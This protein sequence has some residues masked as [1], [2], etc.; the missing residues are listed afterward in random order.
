VQSTTAE[1]EPESTLAARVS[2]SSSPIGGPPRSPWTIL[3]APVRETFVPGQ[4]AT[5]LL[6]ALREEQILR[7]KAGHGFAGFNAEELES[8]AEVVD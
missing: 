7:L 4:E 6:R 1:T 3:V 8:W 5:A 2:P